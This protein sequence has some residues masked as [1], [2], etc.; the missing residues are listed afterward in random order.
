MLNTVLYAQDVVAPNGL[1]FSGPATLNMTALED[2]QYKDYKIHWWENVYGFDMSCMKYLAF[3]EPLVDVVDPKQLVINTFLMKEMDIYTAKVEDF[4]FTPPCCL[5]VK[6]HNYVH[7][8]VAYINIEFTHCHKRTGFSPSPETPY[9]HWKQ[10][11]LYM[12]DYLMVKTGERSMAPLA[13]G[14]MPRIIAT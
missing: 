1:I 13:C 10:T 9:M 6:Q 3:K 11:V 12:E 2:W 4:T 8:L 14:P 7:A 5:Q